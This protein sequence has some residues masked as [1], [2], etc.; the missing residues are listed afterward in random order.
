MELARSRLP[1]RTSRTFVSL[2]QRLFPEQP[3]GTRGDMSHFLDSNLSQ[4]LSHFGLGLPEIIF[5]SKPTYISCRSYL[6][7]GFVRHPQW[8]IVGEHPHRP[9]TPRLGLE[10]ACQYSGLSFP[11]S[12]KKGGWQKKSQEPV[13]QRNGD[14]LSLLGP[15]SPSSLAPWKTAPCVDN[16]GHSW[17]K[18]W[19]WGATAR[20]GW[21][22]PF[23][24]FSI[25]SGS[26]G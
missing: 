10:A 16:L 15:I 9:P 24:L 21:P 22:H 17:L 19:G 23:A 25:C 8:E 3:Q 14:I 20:D 7:I 12:E 2:L 13:S 4:L 5:F 6:P 18:G 1:V 11:Y 26:S